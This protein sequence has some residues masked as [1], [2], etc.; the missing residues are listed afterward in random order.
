MTDSRLQPQPQTFC[1]F[2]HFVC[3]NA[4]TKCHTTQ[5]PFPSLAI[6][7]ISW[8]SLHLILRLAHTVSL[9][10]SS[11]NPS[12]FWHPRLPVPLTTEF[13]RACVRACVRV[14]AA[15]IKGFLCVHNLHC[16]S[17]RPIRHLV[18]PNTWGFLEG[19]TSYLCSGIE[20]TKQ[21]L[22]CVHTQTTR[23]TPSQRF[24]SLS[25][26]GAESIRGYQL[27][28]DTPTLSCLTRWKFWCF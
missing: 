23:R 20:S 3:E 26:K 21:V 25:V 4:R 6:H 17:T 28:F 15:S 1:S 18:I 19:K 10:K 2:P 16:R 14:S 7:L 22:F 12:L 5:P 24:H 8:S 11:L 13:L 27:Q 9:R